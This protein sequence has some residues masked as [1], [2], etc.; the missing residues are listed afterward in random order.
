VGLQFSVRK[1]PKSAFSA[2][3][4]RAQRD[5]PELFGKLEASDW[6]ED[7]RAEEREREVNPQPNRFGGYHSDMQ[8]NTCHPPPLSR[9]LDKSNWSS[10]WQ[11]APK[12]YA[13]V[14]D[15]LQKSRHAEFTSAQHKE[16]MKQLE[17]GESLYVRVET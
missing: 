14:R 16:L 4:D 17:C 8:P 6:E 1:D 5:S 2:I 9:L 13:D 7:D 12:Q 11:D 10:D 3:W 15:Q